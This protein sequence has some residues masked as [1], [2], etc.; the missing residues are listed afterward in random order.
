LDN[1]SKL[2]GEYP[3]S[4]ELFETRLVSVGWREVGGRLGVD[5]V[6]EETVETFLVSFFELVDAVELVWRSSELDEFELLP[7]EF[8]ELGGDDD[9]LYCR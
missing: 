6:L 3:E 2:S 8:E 5:V 9:E 1:R 4:I 7:E